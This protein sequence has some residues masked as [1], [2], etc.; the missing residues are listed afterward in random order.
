MSRQS[1]SR[2]MN[3]KSEY[4]FFPSARPATA[5]PDERQVGS[6]RVKKG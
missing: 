1:V 5:T 2:K 3:S 4:N 6:E